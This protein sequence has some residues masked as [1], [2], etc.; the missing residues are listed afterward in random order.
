VNN[1]S[2]PLKSYSFSNCSNSRFHHREMLLAATSKNSEN[3]KIH[4][5]DLESLN[6]E[7]N[8]IISNSKIQTLE[9]HPERPAVLSS[10]ENTLNVAG[11]DPSGIYGKIEINEENRRN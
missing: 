8:L 1:E 10:T 2:T 5:I 9:F 3:S 11:W 4:F 7:S 6:E